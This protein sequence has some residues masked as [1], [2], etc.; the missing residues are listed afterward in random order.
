M[1]GFESEVKVSQLGKSEQRGFWAQGLVWYLQILLM[2]AK[3]QGG[4]GLLSIHMMYV[5]VAFIVSGFLKK[6]KHA[7]S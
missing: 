2:C 6:K 1:L 7:H 4:P 3:T 5:H